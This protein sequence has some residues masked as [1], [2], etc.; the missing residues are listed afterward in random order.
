[1][2]AWAAWL[3]AARGGRLVVVALPDDYPVRRAPAVS[4]R[5]V[6]KPPAERPQ[7]AGRDQ[8]RRA[9]PGAARL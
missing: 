8:P 3:A 5:T 7:Q 1:L 4:V 2:P 6:D 9:G